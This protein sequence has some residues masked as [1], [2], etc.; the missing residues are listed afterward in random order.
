MHYNPIINSKNVLFTNKKN[1]LFNSL[2][3]LNS[4]EFAN[5]DDPWQPYARAR[6]F[7]TRDTLSHPLGVP[8]SLSASSLTLLPH[9][10]TGAPIATDTRRHRRSSDELLLMRKPACAECVYTPGRRNTKTRVHHHH[11]GCLGK[12]TRL[13]H[14]HT[15]TKAGPCFTRERSVLLC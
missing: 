2:R 12:T 10:R 6:V 5:P 13:T 15:R 9:A 4:A 8:R 14:T 11:Q 1:N 3:T 7:C